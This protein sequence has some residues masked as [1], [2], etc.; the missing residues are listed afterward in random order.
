MT[1]EADPGDLFDSLTD[2]SSSTWS[3]PSCGAVASCRCGRSN[4]IPDASKPIGAGGGS[5]RAQ[6]A[7]TLTYDQWIADRGYNAS[8]RTYRRTND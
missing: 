1:P 5:D 7:G 8:T 4:D 6:S 3:C 2:F